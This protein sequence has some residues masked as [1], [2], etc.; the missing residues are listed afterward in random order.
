MDD[1]PRDVQ[2]SQ[3]AWDLNFEAKRLRDTGLTLREVGE[4]MGGVSAER[5]RQRAARANFAAK[6]GKQSPADRYRAGT[7][8]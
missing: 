5:A 2:I 8:T 6:R 1:L 4:R 3:R 7:F